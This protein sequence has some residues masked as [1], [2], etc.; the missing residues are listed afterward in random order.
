MQNFG[1]GKK[2]KGGQ[3]RVATIE[4]AILNHE[5]HEGSLRIRSGVSSF[6]V[7]RG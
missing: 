2:E 3:M 5:G 4:A 6:V 1:R 7:L